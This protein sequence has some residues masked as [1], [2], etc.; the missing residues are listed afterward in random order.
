MRKETP[1]LLFAL[2]DLGLGEHGGVFSSRVE[3]KLLLFPC[4]D[5]WGCRRSRPTTDED[6]FWPAIDRDI[7]LPRRAI[8]RIPGYGC[9]T[10]SFAGGAWARRCR[11][12]CGGRCGV[13]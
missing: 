7:N 2:A 11:N 3:T 5:P 9:S 1:G 4:L 12:R 8:P 6:R 13:F 10:E